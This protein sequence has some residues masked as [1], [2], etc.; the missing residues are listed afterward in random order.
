MSGDIVEPMKPNT[1]STSETTSAMAVHGA[2]IATFTARLR[3]VLGRSRSSDG[4]VPH[5]AFLW[6]SERRMGST[7][8]AASVDQTRDG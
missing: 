4:P 8:L 2:M 5:G 6:N 7:R 3:Q 1:T